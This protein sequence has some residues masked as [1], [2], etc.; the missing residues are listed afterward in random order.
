MHWNRDNIYIYLWA[1]FLPRMCRWCLALHPRSVIN[2]SHPVNAN[3]ELEPMT[4]LMIALWIM[5]VY[6]YKRSMTNVTF[7]K[8]NPCP[9]PTPPSIHGPSD[10]LT[11][12]RQLQPMLLLFPL[13]SPWLPITLGLLTQTGQLQPT[14]LLAFSTAVRWDGWMPFISRRQTL[15]NTLSHT[16]QGYSVSTARNSCWHALHVIGFCHKKRTIVTC[17]SVDDFMK[18][19]ST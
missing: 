14:L 6:G 10:V 4:S 1:W 15:W 12:T 13:P 19:H 11:Q 2:S 5:T 9:L 7:Y 3:K 17:K 18:T 16:R 8:F